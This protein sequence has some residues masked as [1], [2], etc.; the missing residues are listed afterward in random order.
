[1]YILYLVPETGKISGSYVEYITVRSGAGTTE[2]PYTYAFEKIGTTAVD[3][4]GYLKNTAT[5]A[6]VAFGEGQAITAEQLKTALNLKALA[7][8]DSASGTVE[9]QKITGVKATGD[10]TGTLTGAMEYDSTAIASTG[11]Y[12]PTGS[13][14]GSAISGGSIAVTLDDAEASTAVDMTR[15][16]YTPAGSV[17]VSL[18]NNTVSEITSVGSLPSKAADTFKANTPTTIDVSKFNAGAKATYSHTG[19]SGGSLGTATKGTF[20]QEGMV[21][22]ISDTDAECLVL[23]A[24]ATTQAVTEQ[25]TYTA[26]VYGEDAFDGG[27][28][29]SLGDGFYTAG[30]AAEYTEG[31]FS[32]GTLPT[33]E[34][35]TVDINTATFA[36]E[37]ETGLK[38]TAATYVKQVVATQTFTPTAATLGFSGAEGDLSVSGNYDKAKAGTLAVEVKNAELAVGD[39][40]VAAKTVTVE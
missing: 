11:K 27:T 22:A 38:V 21:A 39:I 36:G 34:D 28:L 6:G 8:K 26:A 3:L 24:A 16:D 9:G 40:D 14:T 30:S 19:F 13:I 17:T 4:T 31:T 5:V 2:D 35:K 10:L 29:A 25:G 12:T 23:T 15:G 37:K 32:A 18:K 33:M 20:A 7:Y 1:M